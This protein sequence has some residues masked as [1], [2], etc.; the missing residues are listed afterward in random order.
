KDYKSINY[1]VL[2]ASCFIHDVY[3]KNK[4]L[5]V[6]RKIGF[7][8]ENITKI[9]DIAVQFRHI[10]KG[11][12]KNFKKS[13]ESEIFLDADNLD[14]LGSIGIA[15]AVS[16]GLSKGFPLFNSKKDSLNDSVYGTVKE[17]T[18]WKKAMFTKKARIIAKK[19][20]GIMG[21]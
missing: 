7:S 15:R 13:T 2:I 6:L 9:I 21:Q 18:T 16:F 17:L 5:K 12:K 3:E 14:A 8:N 10:G 1:E 19:R 20:I 4:T 11:S